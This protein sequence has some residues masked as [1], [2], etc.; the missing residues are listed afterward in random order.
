[1]ERIRSGLR[2]TDFGARSLPILGLVESQAAPKNIARLMSSTEVAG[3]GS[4][5]TAGNYNKSP[6]KAVEEI[7]C[8]W[9]TLLLITSNL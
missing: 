4:V 7:F 9:N 6:R 1:M 3:R 5:S 8:F 2:S